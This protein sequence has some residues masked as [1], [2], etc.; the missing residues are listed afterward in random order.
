M[1]IGSSQGVVTEGLELDLMLCLLQ[2]SPSAVIVV[3]SGGSEQ[4][5]RLFERGQKKRTK[6]TAL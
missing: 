2:V 1:N 6:V 3:T 4:R 5:H